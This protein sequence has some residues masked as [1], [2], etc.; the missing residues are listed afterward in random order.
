MIRTNT[1]MIQGK[2][3]GHMASILILG[4]A[5]SGKSALGEKL[6]LASQSDH[7]YLATAEIR[8]DEM[9]D[10]INHHKERRDNTWLL[11]EE[12]INIA[13][14][15]NKHSKPGTVILIDCLTLWVSNLM[16]QACNIDHKVQALIKAIKHAGG[17]LIFVSNEV[18]LGIVP[19]NQMARDFR[20]HAG[21]TNQQLA[22]AVNTVHFCLSGLPLTLKK[23][24][25][26]TGGLPFSITEKTKGL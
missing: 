17:D 7:I 4:G 11:I 9:Q 3:Q 14:V 2:I 25:E 20:D 6:A 8:D 23:D 13:D 24:G 18:G 1:K 19:M 26:I 16:E 12:T 21:R 15:I 10:R 22:E 5:R